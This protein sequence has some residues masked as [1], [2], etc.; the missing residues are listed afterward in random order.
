MEPY[1]AA[2]RRHW[3]EL[4]GINARSGFYDVDAFRRGSSSLHSMEIEE[5]GPVAGR[6]LLHLQCHF[7]M[8][9]LSWARLGATVTGVDFSQEAIGLARSMREELGIPAEF[10]CTNLYEL[11]RLLGHTFDVVYTSYGVL[12][13]LPDLRRWG[14]I[15]ARCLR[16]GG[17]FYMVEQHPFANVFGGRWEATQLEVRHRYFHSAEPEVSD[18]QGTYADPDAVMANP[19]TYEWQHSLSDVI[20]AVTGAGLR[21]AFLHEFPV[22]AWERL[23]EMERGADRSWRL[24][25]ELADT[26]P[27]TFSL[28]ATRT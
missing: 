19:L 15:I 28:K 6:T 20:N 10:I 7:G 18:G 23:P 25:G 11:P 2:N 17:T 21:I 24:S 4:V 13:W 12:C 9:T 16:P 26:V 3:D 1:F 27:L 22:G 14:E 8:D 5:M